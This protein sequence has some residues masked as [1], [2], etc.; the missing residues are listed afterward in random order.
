MS[1]VK[2][3][4]TALAAGAKSALSR[5]RNSNK[6]N[7]DTKGKNEFRNLIV[8]T[9]ERCGLV[10]KTIVSL[11]TSQW[12][13][14][15]SI[16]AKHIHYQNDKSEYDK[17][18]KTKPD[19]TIVIN[20]NITDLVNSQ[21]QVDGLWLDYMQTYDVVSEDIS[22]ILKST[23]MRGCAVI[24]LSV[25]TRSPS[26]NKPAPL[27][28]ERMVTSINDIFYKYERSAIIPYKDTSTMYNVIFVDK[29]IVKNIKEKS[30]KIYEQ[31]IGEKAYGCERT[32]EWFKEGKHCYGRDRYDP[33]KVALLNHF[34]NY[35]NISTW[36]GQTTDYKRFLAVFGD[37]LL[38][39]LDDSVHCKCCGCII[40][41]CKRKYKLK[42][43]VDI[44]ELF[45]W[46]WLK[47]R[48]NSKYW[49]DGKCLE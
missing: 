48:R 15:K 21:F 28:I 43:G 9:M 6:T 10:G 4:P 1:M 42:E 19:R 17:M 49:V 39:P 23:C 2:G 14:N 37:K 33:L 41:K 11:E 8:D 40:D 18:I 24:G 13:F 12:L 5:S 45:G 26:K 47:E 31:I 30:D 34:V 3:S 22:E 16:D 7:Y 36:R 25:S 46:D 44:L 20:K 38:Q 29:N 27:Q 32:E 35:S